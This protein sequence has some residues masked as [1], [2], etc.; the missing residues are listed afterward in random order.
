MLNIERLIKQKAKQQRA[1]SA[2]SNYRDFSDIVREIGLQYKDISRK[3]RKSW[4][5]RSKNKEL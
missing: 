1:R 2:K 4:Y 5:K 3:V